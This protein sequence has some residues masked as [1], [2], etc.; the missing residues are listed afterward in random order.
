KTFLII[1]IIIILLI[2]LIYLII[3]HNKAESFLS[4][5]EKLEKAKEIKQVIGEGEFPKFD[6]FKNKMKD[7]NAPTDI[8]SY[9][10]MKNLN[11][12]G[13]FNEKAIAKIL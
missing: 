6:R 12:N 11:K 10:D 7:I 4:K 13:K 9:T 8:V 5:E 2:I 1:V 3:N